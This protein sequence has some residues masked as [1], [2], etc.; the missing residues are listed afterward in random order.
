MNRRSLPRYGNRCGLTL[1]DVL[2]AL[3]VLGVLAAILLPAIQKARENVRMLQ[4]RDNLRQIG[5]ASLHHV[6]TK[7]DKFPYTAT[8]GSDDQGI[9]VL[10][11]L[12]PHRSLLAFL[13][14]ASI[15]EMLTPDSLHINDTEFPPNFDSNIARE[16]HSVR[17]SVFLCPSD[18]C[19]P[20]ATNYRAN[21]GFGPGIY[22]PNSCALSGFIGNTGGAF[23]HGK[24]IRPAQFV[25][26]LSNTILYS[27][28]L[29]GDGDPRKFEPK[30]DFSLFPG[31]QVTTAD[32]AIQM[33]SAA[34]SN[35]LRHASYGGWTWMYG[36]W[37][38]TWYNHVLPPNSPISDCSAGTYATAGGG[39]GCYTA[40]SYHPGGVNA[41][42][43]DGSARF[44]SNQ[45]NVEVWRSL[46]S[47]AGED[48]ADY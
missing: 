28:K 40:R 17:L 13:D 24:S 4:C 26:G 21:M 14:Q 6:S 1:P 8:N 45:I 11:S 31:A 35:S 19:Q 23:V 44:V 3:G 2:V 34:M 42:L 41:V 48:L 36:G 20:G 12:S 46:S 47:R 39:P 37:N 16:V 5:L 38:S 32:D 22:G 29:I 9:N 18:A 27:E 33:C 15:A 10:A 7:S 43:G 25:D 30:G